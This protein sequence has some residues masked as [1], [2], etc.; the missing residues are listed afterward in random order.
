MGNELSGGEQQMLAIGRA[1][2]TNPKLLI[3]DE[4]TEGLA[5]RIR[6]EIWA[7]LAALKR[8]GQAILLVDKHLDALREDRRSPCGDREGSRG[9]DRELGRARR[10]RRGAGPLP[11]GVRGEGRR[12]ATSNS[13]EECRG[14]GYDD[15]HNTKK[16]RSGRSRCASH[17]LSAVW[18]SGFSLAPHR[19]SARRRHRLSS[20]GARPSSTGSPT[21]PA[22][23]L[24]A[25]RGKRHS[26]SP[27]SRR[28][29]AGRRAGDRSRREIH[30][31]RTVQLPCA[32]GRVHG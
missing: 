8:E 21:P 6:A 19:H 30:L 27:A 15:H 1:L 2:M 16:A 22:G 14:I 11:S 4:A 7:C 12:P 29:A 25:D 18:S 31:P 3:L 5:P 17:A 32:L 26:R 13:S 9:V 24:P 10:G 20:S 23:P 28:G